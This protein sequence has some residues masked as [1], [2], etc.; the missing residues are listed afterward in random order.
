MVFQWVLC[1]IVVDILGCVNDVVG[2][3]DDFFVLGG[4]FVFVIQVVVGIW[5]WL[6]LLSLMVVDMFVVRIIVVLVQ[7]FIGWEVNVD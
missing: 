6:D 2:V 7:L 3:Y 1:C 5:W 4:D